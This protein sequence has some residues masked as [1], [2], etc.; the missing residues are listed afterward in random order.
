MVS[1]P[2]GVQRRALRGRLEPAGTGCGGTPAVTSGV[3]GS[4]APLGL[5]SPP[6]RGDFGPGASGQLCAR[7]RVSSDCAVTA[8]R[9]VRGPS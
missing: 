1:V 5:G 4:A 2:R 8:R 6:A 3:C 7:S 9:V